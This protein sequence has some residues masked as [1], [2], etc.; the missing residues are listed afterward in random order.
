MAL[1]WV[2][3]GTRARTGLEAIVLAEKGDDPGSV[4][5]AARKGTADGGK[6]AGFL[7]SPLWPVFRLASLI[8]VCTYGS[9]D[10]TVPDM[11]LNAQLHG[12]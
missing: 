7:H 2:S 9:L 8:A 4:A 1:D 6:K 12:R 3:T 10:L 11:D 5:R